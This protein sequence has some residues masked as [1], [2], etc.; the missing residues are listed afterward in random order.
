MKVSFI[1]ASFGL[2]GLAAAQST[3]SP[4]LATN[5]TVLAVFIYHNHCDRTSLYSSDG[6]YSGGLFGS[7]GATM[8]FTDGTFYWNK[9][10]RE[11]SA[12]KIYGTTQIYNEDYVNAEVPNVDISIQSATAF[13]QGVFKPVDLVSSVTSGPSLL[14]SDNSTFMNGPLSGYQ[15]TPITTYRST[16]PQSVYVASSLLQCNYQR[17]SA[18]LYYGSDDYDEA[19]VE[20]MSF[21]VSLYEPYFAG[22]FRKDQ[23]IYYNAYVL[24]DYANQNRLAGN[25]TLLAMSDDDFQRL[26]VYAN[27]LQFNIFA[28]T[29]VAT[30]PDWADD[31][32]DGDR[33]EV[34]GRALAG[35]I[36]LMFRNSVASGG[37]QN[38]FNFVLGD[39]DL[40]L[41]FFAIANLTSRSD[42]FYGLPDL[43]SSMVFELY[44]DDPT[45]RTDGQLDPESIKIAF[46]FRNGTTV[47]DTLT[48]W[49][50]FDEDP[51]G[52]EP[53]G[54]V[55]DR[56]LEKMDTVSIKSVGQWC[57]VCSSQVDFCKTNGN[58][59]SGQP[60]NSPVT[61][62]PDGGKKRM[63]P[64]VAGIIGAIIMLAIVGI[65]AAIA[66]FVFGVGVKRDRRR[67]SVLSSVGSIGRSG[68]KEKMDSEIELP[69]SP[70]AQPMARNFDDEF[71]YGTA[72]TAAT[73]V[74]SPLASPEEA[75]F[76]T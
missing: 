37:W 70:T 43:G 45:L 62:G 34:A 39:Y 33:R 16:D 36:A 3:T 13:M 75:H 56:F 46:G 59:N 73:K 61:S 52:D 76:K 5:G 12:L 24:Y 53:A 9:Y 35:K 15:Y 48:Y 54:M 72:S 66:F 28:N 4:V 6:T 18:N 58:G 26:R 50:L 30:L 41:S 7:P 69:L 22:A 60:S 29:T 25:E 1:A 47:D 11:A 19:Y 17:V 21:Y 71:D 8:C 49:P 68:R 23:M 64:A 2:L 65:L 20:S 74:A 32:Y 27:R 42:N 31:A 40:M 67:S 63:A 10:L 57:S 38:K 14:E 51:Q 55:Y 44:T